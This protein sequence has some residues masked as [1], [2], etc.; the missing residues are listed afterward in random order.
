M[1]RPGSKSTAVVSVNV[2]EK[3]EIKFDAIVKQGSNQNKIVR[4]SFD[5]LKESTGTNIYYYY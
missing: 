4:A 3:G 2:D 5:D 1:G